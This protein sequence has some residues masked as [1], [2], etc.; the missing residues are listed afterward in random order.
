[1]GAVKSICAPNIG[2][3]GRVL[4]A[5]VAVVLLVG[6]AI[7]FEVAVWLGVLLLSLGL[8][9]AFEAARGW[10]ALRACGIKTKW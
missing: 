3:K 1:M 4:R 5:V 2:N 6:A 10:C 9:V 8:F 7:A